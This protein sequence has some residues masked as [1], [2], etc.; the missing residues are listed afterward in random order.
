[1]GLRRETKTI[2]T[3][4]IEIFGQPGGLTGLTSLL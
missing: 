4:H 1:M 2:L 3:G